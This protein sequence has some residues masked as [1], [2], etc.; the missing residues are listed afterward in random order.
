MTPYLLA[1]RQSCVQRCGRYLHLD[2]SIVTL[3]SPHD[4]AENRFSKAAPLAC[5]TYGRQ[6]RTLNWTGIAV[7]ANARSKAGSVQPKRL[8]FTLHS[9][10]RTNLCGRNTLK[11]FLK[12]DDTHF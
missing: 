9:C 3:A 1:F 6:K 10:P 4:P 2:A 11:S 8:S 12:A 7:S 5:E